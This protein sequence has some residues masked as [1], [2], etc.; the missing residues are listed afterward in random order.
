MVSSKIQEGEA[1]NLIIQE[2]EACQSLLKCIEEVH[3]AATNT[4]AVNSPEKMSERSHQTMY[5]AEKGSGTTGNSDKDKDNQYYNVDFIFAS[6]SAVEKLW[7]KA[8]HLF[9]LG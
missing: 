3:E 5:R 9:S 8:M 7:I 6:A 4:S 2:E 1:N